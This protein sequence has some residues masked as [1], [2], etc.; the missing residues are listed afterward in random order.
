MPDPYDLVAQLQRVEHFKQLPAADLRTIIAAGRVRRFA[1]DEVICSE[2]EPCAGM[3]V[4]LRGRVHLRKVGPGGQQ[5]IL[6]V[7]EPIIMFNETPVLDGGPNLATAVAVAESLVWQIGCENF[8]TLLSR[9]PQIGLGLLKVL[10]Q[11]N[12]VLVAQY[13]DLSFRSVQARAAKLL[14]DLSDSGRR[15]IDRRAYP[16]QQMA[17]RIATVPEAFSRALNTFKRH[18]FISSTRAE[19]ALH[20]PDALAHLAAQSPR[21][22]L[23]PQL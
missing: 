16:N 19:I 5:S 22:Q 2:G 14:L 23:P 18:G 6:A 21:A 8:Q 13:E 4:L 17:A 3:F 20:D 9:Y 10:A 11:R 15:P 7:I 12:R 1:T